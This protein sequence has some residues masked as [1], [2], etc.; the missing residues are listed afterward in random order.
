MDCGLW[1]V[2]NRL[3]RRST[4][5]PGRGTFPK[6]SLRR[7]ET[8]ADNCCHP[9]GTNM[10]ASGTALPSL[11]MDC[12][13]V[14]RGRTPSARRTEENNAVSQSSAVER[15]YLQPRS[16]AMLPPMGHHQHS[17]T[18]HENGIV[19]CCPCCLCHSMMLLLATVQCG[20]P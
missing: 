16:G 13:R 8:P 12:D 20:I 6:T 11:G 15:H 3:A 17:T 18:S 19:Q 1:I 5:T 7:F 14:V 10:T 9:E 2:G 4:S